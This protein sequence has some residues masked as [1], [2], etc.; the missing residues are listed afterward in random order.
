[1]CTLMA[2]GKAAQLLLA[3]LVMRN[4][5]ALLQYGKSSTARSTPGKQA[6]PA[7]MVAAA[8]HTHSQVYASSL[9]PWS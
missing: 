1:M 6:V 5:H 3:N 7:P 9:K 2:R 4:I 8:H